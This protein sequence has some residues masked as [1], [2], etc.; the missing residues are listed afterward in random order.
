MNRNTFTPNATQTEGPFRLRKL[1]LTSSARSQESPPRER[2]TCCST[3]A[4]LSWVQDLASDALGG[5]EAAQHC[6]PK[7]IQ[8][9]LR[10]TRQAQP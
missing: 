8:H 7:A 10:V 3:F 4:A 2:V 1:I 9:Y 6:L 5:D